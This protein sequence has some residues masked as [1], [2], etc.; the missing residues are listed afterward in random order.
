M[1][2]QIRQIP[3]LAVSNS[4]KSVCKPDS[5]RWVGRERCGDGSPPTTCDQPDTRAATATRVVAAPARPSKSTRCDRPRASARRSCDAPT[6]ATP[7]R[8]SPP[9]PQHCP[10]L[11]LA[12]VPSPTDR[13]EPEPTGGGRSGVGG[14]PGQR[15]SRPTVQLPLLG[16]R[17][18]GRDLIN[19]LGAFLP[20]PKLHRRLGQGEFELVV[21]QPH[22]PLG[23]RRRTLVRAGN[24]LDESLP[25]A[26]KELVPPLINRLRAYSV[27]TGSFRAG[28]LT[29]QHGEHDSQ[30]LLDRQ[31][32]PRLPHVL[33]SG[34]TS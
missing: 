27:P 13:A 25:A 6:P 2:A 23:S 33:T 26:V 20:D 5:A 28:H 4:L 8:T 11:G 19:V 34:S 7:R 18:L 22:P 29:G 30:L 32:R 21:L 31:P 17:G 3:P 9:A 10:R 15:T 1:T 12:R 24:L 14:R 16:P